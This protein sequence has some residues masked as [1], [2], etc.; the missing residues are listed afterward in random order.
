MDILGVKTV[1]STKN[2][3]TSQSKSS[4]RLKRSKLLKSFRDETLFPQNISSIF[5]FFSI[6]GIAKPNA[7]TFCLLHMGSPGIPDQ[8]QRDLLLFNLLSNRFCYKR[9]F[10]APATP[11]LPHIFQFAELV[12]CISLHSD[13][14]Y[15]RWCNDSLPMHILLPHA[16]ESI[17][18]P[19]ASNDSFNNYLVAS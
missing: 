17:I 1:D 7:N 11:T 8:T 2:E 5:P 15:C 4:I 12:D 9:F 10:A 3:Q 14:Q 13:C 18:I 16:T 6:F 19:C